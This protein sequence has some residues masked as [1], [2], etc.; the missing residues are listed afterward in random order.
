VQSV[1]VRSVLRLPVCVPS[2]W[3]RASRRGKGPVKV[4]RF[5]K[6]PVKVRRFCK[7]PVKVARGLW[8]A[9]GAG[10][11]APARGWLGV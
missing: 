6:G 8:I 5:C 7:G 4:A 3:P 9:L 2:V 11:P 1:C 10:N